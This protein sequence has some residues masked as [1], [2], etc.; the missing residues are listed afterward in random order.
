MQNIQQD[1]IT[2]ILHN[3]YQWLEGSVQE[4]KKTRRNNQIW[5]PEDSVIFFVCLTYD[6]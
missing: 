6:D 1:S 5:E 2:N 3:R 4:K